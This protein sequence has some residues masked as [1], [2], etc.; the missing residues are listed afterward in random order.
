LYQL[1]L[2]QVYDPL[3]VLLGNFPLRFLP[4]EY[5]AGFI[6]GGVLLGILGTRVAAGRYA[7]V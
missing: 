6:V 1:F 7:G 4:W 3:K 2:I 5:S